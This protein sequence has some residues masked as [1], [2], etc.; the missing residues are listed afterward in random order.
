MKYH[1]E[2]N[3]VLG[4]TTKEEQEAELRRQAEEKKRK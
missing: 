4:E 3:I 1:N 2:S